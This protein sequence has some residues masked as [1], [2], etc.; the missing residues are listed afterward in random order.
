MLLYTLPCNAEFDPQTILLKIV[1]NINPVKDTLALFNIER[2]ESDTGTSKCSGYSFHKA[3][4]DSLLLLFTDPEKEKGV[5]WLLKGDLTWGYA[6]HARLFFKA[7]AQDIGSEPALAVAYITS[8]RPGID[9]KAVRIEETSVNSHRCYAVF[10]EARDAELRYPHMTLWALEDTLI[11]IKAEYANEENVA[12]T[13]LYFYR[14]GTRDSV[15]FPIRV[16]V[17]LGISVKISYGIEFEKTILSTLPDFI[18]TRA[19]CEFMGN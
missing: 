19:F 11:P 2:C 4:T 15:Y 1:Q 13:T 18:F 7:T 3:E 16:L 14:W 5:S 9:Y 8:G 17:T 6:P 10:L 12:V